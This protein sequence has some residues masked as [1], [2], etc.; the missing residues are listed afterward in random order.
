MLDIGYG[1]HFESHWFHAFLFPNLAATVTSPH[2]AMNISF[3]QKLKL[4]GIQ[5]L[6]RVITNL[7]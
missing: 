4:I 5:I 1:D 7:A 6:I 3:Q 2:G